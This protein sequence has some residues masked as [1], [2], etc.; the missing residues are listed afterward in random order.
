MSTDLGRSTVRTL[1]CPTKNVRA[2]ARPDEPWFDVPQGSSAAAMGKTMKRIKDLLRPG[3]RNE[4]AWLCLRHVAEDPCRREAGDVDQL[5]AE[6]TPRATERLELRFVTELMAGQA[7]E[8]NVGSEAVLP[9]V[10]GTGSRGHLSVG[11]ARSW[12]LGQ[13][14]ATKQ[15]SYYVL[16]SRNVTDV[17]CE[18]RDV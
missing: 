17:R 4:G 13:W 5:E 10:H 1:A 15:V 3:A 2:H 14:R 12:D 16:R 6:I 18:L 9:E 11:R 7:A 8:I